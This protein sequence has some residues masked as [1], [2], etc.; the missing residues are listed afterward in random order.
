M[1]VIAEPFPRNN[2]FFISTQLFIFQRDLKAIKSP[3]SHFVNNWKEPFLFI[4]ENTNASCLVSQLPPLH[5]VHSK[6]PSKK[7]EQQTQTT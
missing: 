6:T 5:Y 3:F 1:L 7:S 4:E 2:Y